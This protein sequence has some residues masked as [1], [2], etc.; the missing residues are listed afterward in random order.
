M[1]EQKLLGKRAIVTGGATGIGYGIALRFIAEGA[2]VIITDIDTPGGAD[3]AQRLGPNCEFVHQDVSVP[4]DWDNVFAV[5]ADKFSGLDIMVNVAGVTL[6][7]TIEEIDV[8]TWDKTMAINLR[9][10]FLG[11]QGAIKLMKADGGGSIINMASVSS[12]KAQSELVAYNASKAGVD[13]MTKSVALHCARSGYGINVNSINPGVIQ[14]DM[15]KKV[16]SQVEDGEALMDSYR[17]MHPIGRIG[18]PEDVAAMAVYLASEE[19]SF[20]TG[21][22]FTVDGALGLN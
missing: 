8:E 19:A 18:E 10:C 21:S 11:C 1:A 17:A 3:A 5:A 22:A 15:L 20:V 13:M 2:T 4:A 14:T 16:M 6:M 9:S 12:F 7:G